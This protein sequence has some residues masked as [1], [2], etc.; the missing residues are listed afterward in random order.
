MS[1]QTERIGLS[2]NQGGTAEVFELLS[3]WGQKLFIL[4]KSGKGVK[5]MYYPDYE[6]A[7]RYEKEYNTYP[8]A[9]KF[10]PML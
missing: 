5:K 9:G 10:T 7:S 6:E 4:Q 3:L 8:C 2:I 1:M